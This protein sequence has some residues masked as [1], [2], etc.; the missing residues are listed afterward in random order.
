MLSP[1]QPPSLPRAVLQVASQCPPVLF[2]RAHCSFA[3]WQGRRNTDVVHGF[4]FANATQTSSKLQSSEDT[5]F[6]SF[7][8][9]LNGLSWTWGGCLSSNKG[10]TTR[11]CFLSWSPH[12]LGAGF[13]HFIFT[14]P[15]FGSSSSLSLLLTT[16]TCH[17]GS[18]HGELRPI[19]SP[20][21]IPCFLLLGL[22]C[23]SR[24]GG[25]IQTPP[26]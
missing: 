6:S 2:T 18:N 24:W 23:S 13:W 9:G 5:I 20:S 16:K 19:Q 1:A 3:R 8:L 10:M 15:P 12:V 14:S 7:W 17:F 11:A 25:H 4:L 21:I 22:G 26:A